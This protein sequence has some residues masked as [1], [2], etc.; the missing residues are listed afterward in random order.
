M[1]VKDKFNNLDGK[2]ISRNEI[3]NLINQAKKENETEII[4]RLSTI[5]NND[6]DSEYFEVSL[7]K[8]LSSLNAPRHSGIYKEALTECGRLKKGFKFENG[9]I[10]KTPLAIYKKGKTVSYK[11]KKAIIKTVKRTPKK[12]PNY[13]TENFIYS[14]TYSDTKRE[15]INVVESKIS[16][17]K[18]VKNEEAPANDSMYSIEDIPYKL[19]YDAHRGTSFSPEKRAEQHRKEYVNYLDSVYNNNLKKAKKYGIS[20]TEF[21]IDFKR[22]QKG[23]LKRK[24]AYLNSRLGFYS[25][26]ISGGGNFPVARMNKKSKTIDSKLKEL[27]DYMNKYEVFVKNPAAKKIKTGSSEALETLEKKL[28]DQ[29]DHHLL[30]KRGNAIISKVLRKKNLNRQDQI[31]EIAK[32]FEDIYSDKAIEEWVKMTTKATQP[33]SYFKFFLTNSNAKIKRLKEQIELE[34]KLTK[35]FEELGNTEEKFNGGVLINNR[36]ENKLQILFDGKP[37]KEIRD[38]IK[39]RGQ[40][41]KWS[42]KNGVWQRQLNTYSKYSKNDL[43]SFLN[44][45]NLT[46]AEFQSLGIPY[47]EE[48]LNDDF[49]QGLGK[50]VSSDE[51]Y[52]KITEL[53]VKKIQKLKDNKG[54]EKPF[55]FQGFLVPTNFISKN[56]YRGINEFLLMEQGNREGV[57]ANPYF[58]TFKQITELKGT[59]KK[60]S[61][62]SMI[63]YFTV[64]FEFTKD[65]KKYATYNK[66][67][68]QDHLTANGIDK[69]SFDSV[70]KTIPILKYY[71]VFNGDDVLGVDFGLDKLTPI[72]KA[73]LGALKPLKDFNNKE[74]KDNTAELIIK[75]YPKTQPLIFETRKGAFYRL[76]ND[77][78][79]MPNFK[80]F[81]NSIY[82]YSVFFHELIHSTGHK[83]RLNRNLENEFGSKDYAKEELVAEFGAVFLSAQAGFLWRNNTNHEKYLKGWSSVLEEINKDNKLV[84]RAASKAREAADFILNKN[85]AGE[86]KFYKDLLKPKKQV[87]KKQKE[88]VNENQLTLALNKPVTQNNNSLASKMA[89]RQNIQVENYK[90]TDPNIK[91]FLGDLEI[92]HKESLAITLTGGQG[93]GKTRCL[94]RFMNDLAQNYKVGH[95]SIEE[96]PE[97]GLYWKKV[98]EY[99]SEKAMNNIEN[100]EIKTLDDLE[101]LIKNND[102]IC[103]DSFSKLQELHKGFELDKD[104][105]KKYNGKLFIVIFQQTVDKKMRGGSKSQFDGDV[106]LFTEKFS[107]YTQS[108]VYA[109]KNRYQTK[110]LDTL[111]YNIYSGKLQ[112]EKEQN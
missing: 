43:L 78:V 5:L 30:M 107:D 37:S 65:G 111:K 106:I 67:K 21:K 95:A 80:K 38:F 48:P 85:K 54:F 110:P 4:Y 13:N 20:E 55:T 84:M 3:V 79:N 32:G 108:Y 42:P 60:G 49:N 97:S 74:E 86:P 53:M 103:I 89:S 101:N 76:N 61:K 51:I 14:L 45:D 75:N 58:L 66:K 23:Y 28:K 94:F 15:V 71:N 68:M 24:L 59:L 70:V 16:Q 99:I 73:K 10:V 33:L 62:G 36:N 72:E 35:N 63:V 81:K 7:K 56:A 57:F 92:K 1:K 29:E 109:D 98:H 52:N 64:L 17:Y 27:V 91:A 112:E 82:Y 44:N 88:P 87:N 100:P 47:I 25:T 77:S 18:E 96:H 46:V 105:R 90:L 26:M 50:P 9:S 12:N 69:N 34:K 40:A 104:L 8:H 6:L 39:K 31:L 41:F 102:V 19:A 93:S 83:K 2:T 11:N 22:F